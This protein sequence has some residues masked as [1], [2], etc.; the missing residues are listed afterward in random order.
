MPSVTVCPECQEGKHVRVTVAP[1]TETRPRPIWRYD[2]KKC[3]AH[4]VIDENLK[5]SGRPLHAGR[6]AGSD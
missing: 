5:E 1:T 2:C 6:S 3:G 4:W